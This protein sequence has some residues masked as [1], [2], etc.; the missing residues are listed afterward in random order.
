MAQPQHV[1]CRVSTLIKVDQH[2]PRLERPNFDLKAETS[3]VDRARPG[4]LALC[5]EAS[6]SKETIITVAEASHVGTFQEDVCNS[7]N[8]GVRELIRGTL[9]SG[10]LAHLHTELFRNFLG[11]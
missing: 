5:T 10:H 7:T 6:N 2:P 9:V 1:C 4:R 3:S 8:H 11:T